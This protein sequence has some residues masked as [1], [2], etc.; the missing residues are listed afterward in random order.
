MLEVLETFKPQKRLKNLARRQKAL[1]L[2]R[3]HHDDEVDFL[4]MPNPPSNAA[5]GCFEPDFC[6]A[7][8]AAASSTLRIEDADGSYGFR[9]KSSTG[10]A[11]W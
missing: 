6:G 4:G 9:K 8:A 5:N 7:A 11:R 10:C 1:N 2:P 3:Q